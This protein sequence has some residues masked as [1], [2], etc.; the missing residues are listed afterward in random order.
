MGAT[1]DTTSAQYLRALNALVGTRFK[2]VQGYRGG[3]EVNLA[4][5]RLE[6][7]AALNRQNPDFH[8]QLWV[9]LQGMQFK[10]SKSPAPKT[11]RIEPIASE[12]R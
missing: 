5:E 3:N 9:A 1:S 12:V 6:S 7:A 11:E 10:G 2:I 4:M 8:R